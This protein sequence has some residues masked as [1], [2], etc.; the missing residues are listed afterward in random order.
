VASRVAISILLLTVLLT[1]MVAPIGVCALTCERRAESQRH[2]G[3]LSDHMPAMVHRHSSMIHSGID[4]VGAVLVSQS[5]HMT[6]V[7][8]ERLN[9][10]RKV[11]PHLRIVQTSSVVLD[12]TAKFAEPDPPVWSLNSGPPSG[13]SENSAS[14]TILRI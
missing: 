8:A 7:T 9:A 2:C 10:S 13:R 11:V 4:A 6:C 12:R 1:G 3:Q 5:C 14:F